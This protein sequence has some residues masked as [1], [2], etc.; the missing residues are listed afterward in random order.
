MD[1]FKAIDVFIAVAD[2][3]S[4]AAA[5][6]HLR[7]S[8]P[9]ITRIIGDLE[10]T[11]SVTL[12]HRTTRMVTLTDVGQDY[13]EDVRKISND[14]KIAN[15]AVKGAH[16]SPQ[17]NLRVTAP[18]L[19]GQHYVT[20][21]ITEY[22]NAYQDVTVEAMFLDR[23]VSI[24][25]E[26]VDV[27]VRIGRLQDSNLMA[28]KVGSVRPIVCASR[29]YIA[30]Y[31]VP[32]TLQ[33]LDNHSLITTCF[34]DSPSTWLFKDGIKMSVNPR[35]TFT[36]ILSSIA[37]AK[38]GWGITRVLSYQIGPE[39]ESGELVEVLSEFSPE[40]IPIHIVHGEGRRTSAKVRA[41]VDLAAAKIKE[42]N[43]LYD[44]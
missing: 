3:G 22:L 9:S 4:F 28:R 12:F 29:A 19:F 40:P 36:S 11:L 15:D 23:V 16:R 27:A 43:F 13:L 2:Q 21:I 18:T 44:L 30:K 1:Y 8:P 38:S 14:I 7:I 39:I 10:D 24:M 42:N 34:A 31:G 35:L 33:E 32:K 17:G 25:S 26:G 6:R 5:S 20:P 41:F 37:T